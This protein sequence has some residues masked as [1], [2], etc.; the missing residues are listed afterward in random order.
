MTAGRLKVQVRPVTRSTWPDLEALFAREGYPRWCWCMWWRTSRAEFER[1]CTAGRK[2]ALRRLVDSGIP[3]GVL[4]YADGEP[5]GWCSVAP[6]ETYPALERS[7][8]LRR[9][10]ETPVW[11]V[12]CLYVAKPFRGQG[13]VD[14]LLRAAVQYVR[15]QGGTVVEAYPHVRPPGGRASDAY[16]GLLST[17]LRM[18][19][20]EVARPSPDRSVVRYTV[21]RGAARR[22]EA[23]QPR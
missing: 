5:V 20:V 12:T 10:D 11:S 4:A 23:V 2:A 15:A 7:R 22:Q 21:R 3:V 16:M 17:F 18:G 8:K 19:F 14:R 6:R 9:V 13:A 1:L